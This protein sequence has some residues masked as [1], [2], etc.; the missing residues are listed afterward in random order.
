MENAGGKRRSK[1]GKV[2]AFEE[3][4]LKDVPGKPS[5]AHWF[6]HNLSIIFCVPEGYRTIL[7]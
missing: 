3:M 1:L 7:V 6:M 5:C 2:K 4:L